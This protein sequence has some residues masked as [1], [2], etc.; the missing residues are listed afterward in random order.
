MWANEYQRMAMRTNDHGSYKRMFDFF[1]KPHQR[2]DQAQ[3]FNA[4]L[5]LS[6]EVGEFNDAL[7]KNDF[8]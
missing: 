4:T 2:F 6:G 7:K 1:I 5:G 3:L 8:P